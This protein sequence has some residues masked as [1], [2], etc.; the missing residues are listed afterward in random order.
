MWRCSGCSPGCARP[1]RILANTACRTY[2]CGLRR[3][4]ARVATPTVSA[5]S[6]PPAGGTTRCSSVCSAASRGLVAESE[7]AHAGEDDRGYEPGT[8]QPN[9][10]A[11]DYRL[12]PLCRGLL[13]CGRG[14]RSASNTPRCRSTASRP[15]RT[16][17]ASP[18][19][20]AVRTASGRSSTAMATTH[21]SIRARPPRRRRSR[22]TGSQSRSG[23]LRSGRRPARQGVPER[24]AES[25]RL[26]GCVGVNRPS[27]TRATPAWVASSARA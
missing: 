1:T 3:E 19:S 26:A 10:H 24:G 15:S 21:R 17:C 27:C 25:R 2:A 13:P 6:R 16:P 5:S 14:S 4:A 7:E 11:E 18:T 9:Q 8:W 23:R 12:R 20:T 22:A